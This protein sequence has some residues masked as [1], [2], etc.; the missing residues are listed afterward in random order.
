MGSVIKK[1]REIAMMYSFENRHLFDCTKEEKESCL[2]TIQQMI[3]LADIARNN[4]LF[5][6][7][8]Y[9]VELIATM[10]DESE[11]KEFLEKQGQRKKEG[12]NNLQDEVDKSDDS[13]LKK[14]MQLLI[15]GVD[16]EPFITIMNYSMVSSRCC[17]V[18]LLKK[19]LIFEGMISIRVGH[20]PRIIKEKLFSI[21]GDEFA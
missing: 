5:I 10:E 13:F 21:L 1:E 17:G 11:K 3:S 7:D 6:D 4:F 15:D 2:E 19:L 12:W 20:S 14:G 16:L 9:T 8:M 18:S